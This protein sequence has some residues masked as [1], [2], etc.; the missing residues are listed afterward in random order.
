MSRTFRLPS[1]NLSVQFA[2]AHARVAVRRSFT[3]AVEILRR[4]GIALDSA[5]AIAARFFGAVAK[6]AA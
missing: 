1:L 6:V 3:G 2:L 5:I 4:A